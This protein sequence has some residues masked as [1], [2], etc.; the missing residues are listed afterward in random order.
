[1]K[2]G[3]N[4]SLLVV[5]NICLINTA[6]MGCQITFAFTARHF[7]YTV[8]NCTNNLHLDVPAGLWA[9]VCLKTLFLWCFYVLSVLVTKQLLIIRCPPCYFLNQTDHT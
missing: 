6:S 5:D 2:Q 1:M 4:T 7:C 9:L 3:W 8:R